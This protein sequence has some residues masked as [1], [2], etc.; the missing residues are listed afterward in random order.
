[1]FL[2][3]SHLGELEYYTFLKIF[4]FGQIW[5]GVAQGCPLCPILT[6]EESRVTTVISSSI[7]IIAKPCHLI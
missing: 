2:L 3:I 1:M 6:K 7:F 4:I 5:I